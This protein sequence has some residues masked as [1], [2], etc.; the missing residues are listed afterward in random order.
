MFKFINDVTMNR[1]LILT[2]NLSFTPLRQ[3]NDL[4]DLRP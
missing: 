4:R 3:K 1:S 2:R